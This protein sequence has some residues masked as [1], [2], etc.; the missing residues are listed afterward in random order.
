MIT[1][2]KKCSPPVAT[3]RGSE[4]GESGFIREWVIVCWWKRKRQTERELFLA[5]ETETGWITEADTVKYEKMKRFYRQGLCYCWK[6]ETTKMI[7]WRKIKLK[8]DFRRYL[9]VLEAESLGEI[10]LEVIYRVLNPL[11]FCAEFLK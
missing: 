5:D 2:M 11:K 10:L 7:F 1:P 8:S 9:I 4:G 3:S 6:E